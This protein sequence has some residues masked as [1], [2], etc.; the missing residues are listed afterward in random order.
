M[1]RFFKDNWLSIVVNF[2]VVALFAGVI[3]FSLTYQAVPVEAQ[4]QFYGTNLHNYLIFEHSVLTFS[5][6]VVLIVGNIVI[7]KH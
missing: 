2:L 6:V 7:R 1:K 5:C 4:H 3:L